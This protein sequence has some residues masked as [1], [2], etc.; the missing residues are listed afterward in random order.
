MEDRIKNPY[1]REAKAKEPS[2]TSDII[3]AISSVCLIIFP[4]AS[5]ILSAFLW[6]RLKKGGV[7]TK[8]ATILIIL[9]IVFLPIWTML[10]FQVI[11]GIR[12]SAEVNCLSNL[13]QNAN[14]LSL[15]AEDN[16]GRLPSAENWQDVIG[17]YFP[18]G[19]NHSFFVKKHT[20]AMNKSL[21]NAKISHIKNPERTV[22]LFESPLG[23][24]YGDEKDVL[25]PMICGV[26]TFA[27]G[28]SKG[29]VPPKEVKILLLT[30]QD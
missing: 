18:T 27:D 24:K 5:L 3:T 16:D 11:S 26:V 7:K 6:F 2:K 10:I 1:S 15:Y 22:L 9:N 30:E 21:S 12:M 8:T 4:P 29:K 17:I 23:V 20:H 19:E 13:M 25:E 14:A 28:R